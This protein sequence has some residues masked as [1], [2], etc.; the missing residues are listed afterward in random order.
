[1]G[2]GWP[3]D[4]RGCAG[5]RAAGTWS[6]AGLFNTYFWVDPVRGVAGVLLT[7]LLPFGDHA[8]LDLFEQFERAIY[9]TTKGSP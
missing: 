7:Q 5:R 9:S 8:V 3:A 1:M 4:D 2:V 6:W